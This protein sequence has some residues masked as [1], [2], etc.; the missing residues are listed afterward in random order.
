MTVKIL[1][2]HITTFPSA[3]RYVFSRLRF[4]QG[5][6]SPLLILSSLDECIYMYVNTKF[7]TWQLILKFCNYIHAVNSK[8]TTRHN[9][10]K[11]CLVFQ[12]IL[13]V[14]QKYLKKKITLTPETWY[15]V[16]ILLRVI[17]CVICLEWVLFIFI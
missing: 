1:Y 12:V 13:K 6:V 17:K 2:P 15:I 4:V 3:Q 10:I 7:T 5:T 14:L 8:F 9:H 11:L 16:T